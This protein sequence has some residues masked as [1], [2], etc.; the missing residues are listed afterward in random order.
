MVHD[1]GIT[2]AVHAEYIAEIARELTYDQFK[3]DSYN[4][5]LNVYTTI[6]SDHQKA[7]LSGSA[8]WPARL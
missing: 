6:M 5:G 1:A 8:K 2:F 3:E 4:R 7:R